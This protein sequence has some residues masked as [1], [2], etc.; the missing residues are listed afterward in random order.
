MEVVVRKLRLRAL[1]NPCNDHSLA[2]VCRSGRNLAA[3]VVLVR[4]NL[5]RDAPLAVEAVVVG[6]RSDGFGP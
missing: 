4:R 5:A 3:Q 6:A 2:R 1:H